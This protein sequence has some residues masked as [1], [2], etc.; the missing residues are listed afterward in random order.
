DAM[1]KIGDQLYASG[2]PS[3]PMSYNGVQL[4]QGAIDELNK[5][6]PDGQK[7]G[8][9]IYILDGDGNKHVMPVVTQASVADP[10]H[11]ATDNRETN[12]NNKP[13]FQ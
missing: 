5:T 1:T 8:T 11:K 3:D 4:S 12:E 7:L 6:R 13:A 2:D 10:D 9:D